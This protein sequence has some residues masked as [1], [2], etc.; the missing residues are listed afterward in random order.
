MAY[1]PTIGLEIHIEP[2][3]KTKMFC[4]CANDPFKAKPNANVCPICLAHPGTLPTI[5]KEAVE[6]T[7]KLGLALNGKIADLSHFDRKSYFYPDLPKGYQISQYKS[8]LV[9]GGM[10][11]DVR[12]TRVHLEEDTGKL[13]HAKDKKSSNVDLNRAG[14]PLM[15]LVTEPDIKNGKQAMEFAKELQLTLRYLRVSNAD[16]EKGEMRVE[17]N[18]SISKD[19]KTLGTK[20]EIKNLNSFKIVGDAIN[21]EIKR[22]EKLLGRGDKIVQETRGWDEKKQ[23]T[24]SQRSKEEAHD[25]RYFPEPDLPELDLTDPNYIDTE[26]LFRE[27][28]ELPQAKR[29]R[30]KSEYGLNEKQA[31]TLVA[32][33]R[34]AEFYEQAVS[35]CKTEDAKKCSS[36]IYNYLTSDLFGLL[37]EK[38]ISFED[39]KINPENFADLA[40]LA[41][42]GEL[43]SR[44]VKDIL[45]KMAETGEDPRAIMDKEGI[46]QVSDEDAILK[47]IQKVIGENEQAVKDYKGGNENTLKFLIGQTM[48]EL[49]GQ[50]NPQRIQKI[51]KKELS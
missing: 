37:K 18:I 21:D 45:P 42:K 20:V 29:D 41:S 31:D 12:I 6:A 36:L 25:Y 22:Q 10:L 15:E 32:E 14:V 43:S 4:G 13:L 48:K 51:L 34:A 7:I 26:L 3:T 27:L 28:P 38:N 16:M 40:A 9:E 11:K 33:P 1:I 19:K 2:K 46:E 23:K 44:M 30:F 47:V 35:E 17:A 50:G 39:L 5:N 24:V 8:P 49:K